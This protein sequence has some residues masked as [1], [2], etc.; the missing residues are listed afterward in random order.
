MKLYG[1]RKKNVN[2][3]TSQNKDDSE[4]T[5]EIEIT[6]RPKSQHLVLIYQNNGKPYQLKGGTG[7]FELSKSS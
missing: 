4:I 2:C 6:L 5:S 3:S 7:T 1:T